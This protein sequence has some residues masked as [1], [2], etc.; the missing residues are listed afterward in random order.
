M[1]IDSNV[2]LRAIVPDTTAAIQG[3]VN[4]GQ[5][6]RNAPLLREQRQN[7]IQQQEQQI[8]QTAIDTGNAFSLGTYQ[9]SPETPITA[10]NYQSK[11]SQLQQLGHPL[12]E[13]D[14]IVSEENISNLE[15][16]RQKGRADAQAALGGRSGV[17]ANAPII[18]EQPKVDAD[19]IPVTDSAGNPVMQKFFTSLKTNRNTGE[20][21]VSSVPID[22]Q[23]VDRLGLNV[24]ERVD[25]E[26]QKEL[27]KFQA[28][29]ESQPSV[30]AAESGA[31]R[32]Q[33]AIDEAFTTGD[34][35]PVLN[36]ALSLLDEVETGGIDAA[37]LRAK[38]LFGIEGADEGELSNLMGKAVLAQLRTTFGAAFTEGEGNSL[39][40][41]EAG[42]GK[43]AAANRRL[44]ENAKATASRAVK[45]GI[46]EA[47]KAGQDD[48]VK[49]LELLLTATMEGDS[50]QEVKPSTVGRF[51]VRAK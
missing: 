45:R 47:K 17:Q 8:D 4:L 40:R 1:A 14:F 31:R 44:L 15:A 18:T 30:I 46:R 51:T 26:K 10:E 22:G 35:I 33:K 50:P 9:L 43:S 29:T 23:V 24:N 32:G 7:A 2:L 49:E 20:Q 19:G 11:I 41:I 5:T 25:E 27:A 36:R 21:E 12:E 13:D 38:Q 37:N 34:G 16:I 3:G 39:K 6:I 42:F 28:K 48:V